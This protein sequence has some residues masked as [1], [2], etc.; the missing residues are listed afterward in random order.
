MPVLV[1]SEHLN[2]NVSGC[3]ILFQMIEHRPAQH[4]RQEDVEGYRSRVEFAGESE[5]FRSLHCDQDLET[6]VTRK[7]AKDLSIMRIILDDEQH[8]ILGLKIVAV[9]RDMLDLMLRDLHTR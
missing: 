6:F 9:I 8:R 3:G 5:T 7:V 1:Q 4:V 2:R